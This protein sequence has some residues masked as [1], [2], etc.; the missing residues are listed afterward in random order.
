MDRFKDLLWFEH[1]RKTKVHLIGLGGIGSWVALLAARA[2]FS[3]STVDFDDIDRTNVSGQLFGTTQVGHHK[4][5]AVISMVEFYTGQ[6]ISGSYEKFEPD[7]SIINKGFVIAA[8]DSMKARKDLFNAYR[9]KIERG[10]ITLIDGRLLAEQYEIFVI[11]TK[12][13]ADRYEK[14]FL[15]TD[16]EVP[17]VACTA[18]QTSHYAAAIAADIVRFMTNSLLVS[19]EQIPAFVPFQYNVNGV[20]G[21]V[22]KPAPLNVPAG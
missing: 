19:Y 13:E 15:Y 14:E 5:D 8:L 3:L 20:V 11:R 12:E 17:D 1:A 2:G 10:V 7:S 21:D 4:V 9:S 6:Y 16:E 18:K 22:I